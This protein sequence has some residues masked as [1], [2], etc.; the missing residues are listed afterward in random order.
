[1]TR[2]VAATA[3]LFSVA[4]PAQAHTEEE[5]EAWLS[6]FNRIRA[7]VETPETPLSL[8]EAE[9]LYADL[10]VIFDDMRDRHPCS[11]VLGTPC[12]VTTSPVGPAHDHRGVGTG[13]SG[14]GNGDAEA[15]RSL[16]EVYFGANTD[17]ALRV[18]ACE[19]GFNPGAKNPRSSASG[20]FQFLSSTWERTTGE[21]YPGNV[22]D[23]E[24]NIAAAAKLSKGGSDWG[25]WSCRP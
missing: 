20:M 11:E 18:A 14:M 22:F 19:S 5:L 21:S 7:Y 8:P 13:Y 4:L 2:T 24:S 3:L 1:M 17:A 6:E 25:Q 16:F 10:N 15:W 23:A 9:A 12:P